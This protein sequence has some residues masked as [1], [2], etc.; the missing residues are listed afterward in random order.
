MNLVFLCIGLLGH[1]HL[2]KMCQHFKC[3][4]RVQQH[5]QRNV[6]VYILCTT[7]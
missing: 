3:N 2:Q 6:C 5:N 7:K 1:L 4:V